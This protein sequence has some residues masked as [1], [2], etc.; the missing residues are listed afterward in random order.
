LFRFNFARSLIQY[1]TFG[2]RTEFIKSNIKDDILKSFTGYEQDKG[3]EL[4]F[5]QA[6][7]YMNDIGRFVEEDSNKGEID[8]QASLNW[9]IHCYNNALI[10]VDMDGNKATLVIAKHTIEKYAISKSKSGKLY[11]SSKVSVAS[12]G[13]LDI[14]NVEITTQTYNS[15]TVNWDITKKDSYTLNGFVNSEGRFI[16]NTDELNDKMGIK[17]KDAIPTYEDKFNSK[18]EVLLA[19]QLS[20]NN[21]MP[22]VISNNS[23]G[24]YNFLCLNDLDKSSRAALE[25]DLSNKGF[26]QGDNYLRIDRHKTEITQLAIEISNTGTFITFNGGTYYG[27]D[28]GWYKSELSKGQA[29]S[30]KAESGC[31]SIAATNILA[32]YA[33]RNTNNKGAQLLPT[34]VTSSTMTRADYI[35]FANDI[36]MNY[37]H[38]IVW[39]L[40]V[41]SSDS[42]IEGM[43]EYGK[44]R[45]VTLK[46]YRLGNNDASWEDAYDFIKT[47]LSFDCPVAL[48]VKWN[49]YVASLSEYNITAD[50]HWVTITEL[51]KHVEDEYLVDAK[52]DNQIGGLIS[53]EYVD[54]SV[55]ISTWGRKTEIPSF[56]SAWE[57]NSIR[58]N[59]TSHGDS[60][61][62]ILLSFQVV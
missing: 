45:N 14:L 30:T 53:S 46:A 57:D 8:N 60:G 25:A 47:G 26:I 6:R 22:A 7:Y 15:K 58:S 36:Y 40:G 33:Q 9:Y 29:G 5:V 44:T 51:F 12:V 59:L 1:N 24:E 41:W 43:L 35:N 34:H 31:G 2:K 54:F 37:V 13:K 21:A 48:L 62:V 11:V 27:G 50:Y 38:Q 32:Y 18:E 16:V 28:Q 61:N 10:Y 17:S 4:D 20:Y 39:G 19:F 56:R 52:T 55:S 49:K 23:F 3:T 42:F